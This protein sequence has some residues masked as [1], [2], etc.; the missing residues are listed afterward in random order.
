LAIVL[1]DYVG[2]AIV[3]WSYAG[4]EGLTAHDRILYEGLSAYSGV[5]ATLLIAVAILLLL[6]FLPRTRKTPRAIAMMLFGL[7]AIAATIHLVTVRMGWIMSEIRA[8]PDL[9]ES[10]TG[11]AWIILIAAAAAAILVQSRLPAR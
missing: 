7:L 8:L 9:V 1:P 10:L 3:L 6:E 11:N 2:L 5:V 4:H